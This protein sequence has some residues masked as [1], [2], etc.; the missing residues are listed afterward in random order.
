[1]SGIGTPGSGGGRGPLPRVVPPP[2][3][4]QGARGPKPAPERPSGAGKPALPGTA[5]PGRAAPGEAARLDPAEQR[6]R[7]RISTRG[8]EGENVIAFAVGDAAPDAAAMDALATRLEADHGPEAKAADAVVEVDA[9]ASRLGSPEDNQTLSRLRGDAVAAGLKERGFR[10]TITVNAHGESAGEAV[11][12]P[13]GRD[14]ADDRIVA[15]TVNP[16][17]RTPDTKVEGGPGVRSERAIERELIAADAKAGEDVMRYVAIPT[18]ER[19]RG[20]HPVEANPFGDAPSADPLV[21]GKQALGVI[22]EGIGAARSP[23]KAVKAAAKYTV[24]PLYD[25]VIGNKDREAAADAR[26]PHYGA[27]ADAIAAA[28]DPAHRPGP[29][30][31]PQ[32]QNEFDAVFRR[33][34]RLNSE[35]KTQLEVFLRVEAERWKLGQVREGY[36]LV[37]PDRPD[38]AGIARAA[39]S[40]FE[41][42]RHF[43]RE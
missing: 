36:D 2:A 15:V 3:A 35:Q 26:R 28:L 25:A 10:G 21:F 23:K 41:Q 13:D 29:Q 34:D 20:E 40:Y 4:P 16:S 32:L 19:I 17:Y 33:A 39:E 9:Y 12:R 22:K 37:L 6:E 1:M 43:S 7:A 31:S 14:N 18:A 24:G 5:A 8:S 42:S 11:G 27:V 38:G 30:K